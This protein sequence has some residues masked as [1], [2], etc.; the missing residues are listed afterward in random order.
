MTIKL[1]PGAPIEITRRLGPHERLIWWNRPISALCAKREVNFGLLFGAFFLG[2][3]L[4]WIWQA[5]SAPG[6]FFLFGIPFVLIGLWMVCAPVRAYQRAKSTLFALTDRSAMVLTGSTART[7]PLEQ[8]EFVETESFAD[9]SGHVEFHKEAPTPAAW[10]G[11][12]PWMPQKSGFIGVRDAERVGREMLD[13]RESGGLAV[14]CSQGKVMPDMLATLRDEGDA[15]P[16]KT[17]QGGG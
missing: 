4:F 5:S 16:Y 1:P 8:I 7:F 9:G 14:V 15:A 11:N 2:F 10:T 3:A 17:P 6:P 12:T 13:L